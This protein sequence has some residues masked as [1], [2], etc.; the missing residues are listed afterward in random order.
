MKSSPVGVSFSGF[1]MNMLSEF[2]DELYELLLEGYLEVDMKEQALERY[3]EEE[4]E[5]LVRS[6]V[7]RLILRLSA[8]GERSVIRSKKP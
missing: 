7:E 5:R 4:K 2:P 8:S 1:Q 3:L 6:A